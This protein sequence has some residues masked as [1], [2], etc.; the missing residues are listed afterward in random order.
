MAKFLDDLSN[1]LKKAAQETS[2]GL[3]K[4]A[5]TAVKQASGS[6]SGSSKKNVWSESLAPKS[7]GGSSKSSGS[8]SSSSSGSKSS[9][10][11]SSSGGTSTKKQNNSFY[12]DYQARKQQQSR[13]TFTPSTMLMN[14]QTKKSNSSF[15]DDYQARKK[16]QQSGRFT[17][18]LLNTGSS[19][20]RFTPSV[21]RQPTAQDWSASL[22]PVRMRD[23][24]STETSAATQ[25]RKAAVKQDILNNSKYRFTD[26]EVDS[27]INSQNPREDMTALVK[28]KGGS[29]TEAQR[30]GEYVYYNLLDDTH[31]KQYNKDMDATERQGLGAQYTTDFETQ[32][33]RT[34][35]LNHMQN[36]T[37]TDPNSFDSKATEKLRKGLEWGGKFKSWLGNSV[38]SGMGQFNNSIMNALDFIIPT[39]FLGEKDPLKKAKGYYKGL[40][41]GYTNTA[42]TRAD[43]LGGKGWHTATDLTATVTAAI[44]QAVTAFMTGGTSAAGSLAP[45]G[46]A[47]AGSAAAAAANGVPTWGYT[48]ANIAQN[49]MKTPSFWLSF[50]TEAG[51]QYEGAKDKGASETQA[52]LSGLV[53]GYLNGLVEVG[54][55]IEAIPGAERGLKTFVKSSLE[56]GLEENAQG[57]IGNLV[58]KAV[59]DKD[60]QMFSLDDEDAVVN[61]KRMGE[62]FAGGALAGGILGGVPMAVGYAADTN[63]LGQMYRDAGAVQDVIDEGKA[64]GTG[65]KAYRQAQNMNADTASNF[66]VGRQANLNAEAM[67]DEARMAQLIN[68]RTGYDVN[69]RL[70]MPSW[71]AGEIR[72]NDININANKGQRV[73]TVLHEV[74]HID[75]PEAQAAADKTIEVLQKPAYKAQLDAR[76]NALRQL[77]EREGNPYTEKMLLND[78]AVDMRR[79]GLLYR[80][81]ADY[82]RATRTDNYNRDRFIPNTVRRA[83]STVRSVFGGTVTNENAGIT[84]SAKDANTIREAW[85]RADNASAGAHRN[86]NPSVSY[87]DSSPNRGASGETAYSVETDENGSKY[88]KVD[89][90]QDIFDGIDEKDYNQVAR[91][92]ILDYLRGEI[93][94]GENNTATIDRR[95]GEKY[96]N[97][98]KR[99]SNFTEKMRLAPE[100]QN[101]LSI[102]R[103]VS[104]SSST[105]SNSRYSSYEYYDFDFELGGKRFNALINIGVDK[106]GNRYFYDI[107]KIHTVG[108][109]AQ[110]N[111]THSHTNNMYN[112]NISQNN[113]N[114]KTDYSV[115]TS[116]Q[117]RT[118]DNVK[119]S[120]ITDPDTGRNLRY[121]S[122]EEDTHFPDEG[123]WRPYTHGSK[124]QIK[125]LIR[126]GQQAEDNAELRYLAEDRYGRDAYPLLRMGYEN[127]DM[128]VDEYVDNLKEKE[129][130]RV[131]EPRVRVGY[132]GDHDYYYDL[133]NNFADDR[134]EYGVSA[135]SGDWLN[136][137]KST[138]YGTD[139]AK[140]KARGIYKVKGI[141]LPY[142]GGDGEPM[143]F[144]TDWAEKTRIRTRA[145]LEK[146]V[147]QLERQY[148]DVQYSVDTSEQTRTEEFN[149]KQRQLDII[150][151]ANPAFNDYSTW[152]RTADD[153]RTFEETLSDGDYEE[154]EDFDPDYTYDMALEAID[155]GKITVYSSYPI[156][157]GIFVTPSRMEA[158]AYA[159]SGKVYSKTVNLS[160]VAWIDPTQGQ[161]AKIDDADIR[162]SVDTNAD[163]H[164]PQQQRVIDEYEAAVDSGLIRYMDS[165]KDGRTR[166]YYR[167]SKISDRAAHEIKSKLG[168]DVSGSYNTIDKYAIEHIEND[169]GANGTA[170]QSMADSRDIARIG[171]VLDNYDTM[172]VSETT[173]WRFKNKDN[174]PAK[175]VVF[176]KRIDGSYYVVE[177]VP[178]TGRLSVI[179]A[180]KNKASEV[181]DVQNM[182]PGQTSDNALPNNASTDN[183]SQ[184]NE[185]V[186]HSVDTN[187]ES[188][189]AAPAPNEE[190]WENLMTG[191]EAEN[192]AQ[193]QSAE[194][195]TEAERRTQIFMEQQGVTSPRELA[196]DTVTRRQSE[197]ERSLWKSPSP[198]RKAMG[199]AYTA[200]VDDMH[201]FWNYNKAYERASKT[202]TYGKDNPYKL[203]INAKDASSRAAY[204]V[205]DE[206]VDYDNNSIGKGLVD[207][208][209]DSGITKDTYDEFN[210]YLVARHALEWLDPD[211]HGAVKNVYDDPRL[212]DMGVVQMMT[213]DF[214]NAHPE[215][216]QA[217]DNLYEWQRKLMKT[218]LVDTGVITQEQYDTFTQMYPDYVPFFREQDTTLGRGKVGMAN[219]GEVIKEAVGSES[220]RI[221]EPIEN[222]MYNVASY[223][224][225]GTKHEV[226]KTAV[227]QYDMLDSDPENNV[228]RQYWEE[229]VPVNPEQE[230]SLY[231]RPKRG[232]DP[233]VDDA[234]NEGE[235]SIS[236]TLRQQ[237][238]V[239][240]G[241]VSFLDN[242]KMRYFRV[243]DKDFLNVLDNVRK[244]RDGVLAMFAAFSRTRAALITSFNPAFSLASNPVRDFGT[245][246]TNSTDANKAKIAAGAVSSYYDIAKKSDAYKSYLAMG[247][248]YS[249]IN[250]EGMTAM[251]Q[252]LQK[253]QE[254][255]PNLAKRF[256]K[257]FPKGFGV[258]QTVSDAIEAAPRMAEFKSTLK[259]GYDYH[260]AFY[261]AKDVTTNFSRG[262]QIAKELNAVSNFFNA[263]IQGVDKFFRQAKNNPKSFAIGIACLTVPALLAWAWNH[264]G[265][266]KDKK[267]AYD[268]LS[269]YHK[270]NSYNFYIGNGKFVSIP[271]ARESAVITSS[272]EMALDK[273]LAKESDR[274]KDFFADYLLSQFLPDG[275]IIGLSTINDLRANEDYMGKPIISDELLEK[276][277]EQQFDDSTSYLAR[278]ISGGISRISGWLGHAINVSPKKIDY[279]INSE[280]GVLGKINRTYFTP[281]SKDDKAAM[282]SFGVLGTYVKDSLFSTDNLNMFYDNKEKA[283]KQ[284]NGYPSADTTYLSNKY[285]QASGVLSVLNKMYKENSQTDEG[286]EIRKQYVRF[287]RNNKDNPTGLSDEVYNEI[288][289]LYDTDSGVLSLPKV[290]RTIKSD[291]ASYTFDDAE[292]VIRYQRDINQAIDKAYRDLVNDDVYS[293]MTDSD[294]AKALIKAKEDAVGEVRKYYVQGLS[295]SPLNDEQKQVQDVYDKEDFRLDEWEKENSINKQSG[296]QY[297]K[298][299]HD[300]YELTNEQKTKYIYD[301]E[302][303][304]NQYNSELINGSKKI[305]DII[306]E[307]NFMLYADEMTPEQY[308]AK[309]AACKDNESREKF[310]NGESQKKVSVTGNYSDWGERVQKKILNK[311]ASTV[312]K[313]VETEM[314]ADIKENGKLYYKDPSHARDK[315]A[316]ETTTETTEET[317]GEPVQVSKANPSVGYADSSPT[318]GASRS[319]GGSSRSTS[320]SGSSS[321]G[322]SGG[323]TSRVKFTPSGGSRANPSVGYADSSPNRGASQGGTAARL[324]FTPSGTTSGA[325]QFTPTASVASAQRFI[326]ST[327]ETA[328]QM[329]F[330]PRTEN[331]VKPKEIKAVQPMQMI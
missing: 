270:N 263:S 23:M 51:N 331:A 175:K 209:T 119:Y 16:Q 134:P 239:R 128:N 200:V 288:K 14:K 315:T 223:V 206:M 150:L 130:Y 89:T 5:E 50:L 96:T 202:T 195:R 196:P 57:M 171:Y 66:R 35:A 250:T 266:D 277:D 75:T 116:E 216:K 97:P 90:D 102:A 145:G 168:T 303:R 167:I 2:A 255:D 140:L 94:L 98:G 105:K 40:E 173:D 252:A 158:E 312:K 296:K 144:P 114:V 84:V 164:T 179:T 69:Y 232:D 56:E 328:R 176:E 6:S 121:F 4:A 318:R 17:P 78:I 41:Q 138:F 38:M 210:K 260:E 10:S 72:G 7:I 49:A 264:L 33:V 307:P 80:T 118:G 276:P 108:G 256:F 77:Y 60:K 146:A 86:T 265:D 207:T 25:R 320:R 53:T 326:P 198:V 27:V 247:G 218:W 36:N 217:A 193:R 194:N 20:R 112:N 129:Y 87:A 45:A 293:S 21:R 79:G 299:G 325:A 283:D 92:Y 187:A 282:Y 91:M 251:Q 304:T 181:S 258:Y 115:D 205:T 219:Q 327:R 321:G 226:I 290:D 74:G 228:L 85:E 197:K 54:G 30:Y 107:N 267:E 153:I 245:L 43:E 229:V 44:P 15:Y 274:D 215:F 18:S 271:K 172:T 313:D 29:D 103:K 67:T 65:T 190:D 8:G 211:G 294:K 11:S 71:N 249:S 166:W 39:D 221:L 63:R 191:S 308:E 257:L 142:T 132:N 174:T 188:E 13:A 214:E 59:W 178:D 160:D 28:R 81:S 323:G 279:I 76:V 47:F 82:D 248:Q 254:K 268:N 236:S 156:E 58:D 37:L 199:K 212:N 24:L 242:G 46:G 241:V 19:A 61:P 306:S 136:S 301:I 177:A 244:G 32:K 275:S 3:K 95:S 34:D 182:N 48:A 203:S 208:I 213:E 309:L 70:D 259:N 111:G 243:Y 220:R 278:G 305:E 227:R 143:I 26:L 124:E 189:D 157:Q 162:Y 161:Y 322:S 147:K 137:L 287:A 68:E 127:P 284:A 101:V 300:T 261:R 135:I 126:M 141:E 192:Q 149:H 233:S 122:S 151:N 186:K 170:D 317:T 120:V 295:E 253:L 55:G 231:F 292:S 152:I 117:T 52:V 286:R 88:I 106:E 155:T 222:I 109:I 62:E 42:H 184:N 201:P 246:I 204:I 291:G 330:I 83:T 234:T 230:Q 289:G 9:G 64:Q 185:N 224:N 163:E 225:H 125:E 22:S 165:I 273:F 298:Y 110:P 100:L 297:V 316:E 180:Y 311:V 238:D 235:R 99:Q 280:T 133:S 329:R 131:G 314:E 269:N 272:I 1:A 93:P 148:A 139:D 302:T 240:N 104:E 324:K 169:H 285:T 12:E 319:G 159:G 262:G 31:K 73:D 183:I 123:A 237:S 154:G 310:I 281:S 113:E